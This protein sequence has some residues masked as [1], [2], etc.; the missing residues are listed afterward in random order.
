MRL[1]NIPDQEVIAFIKAE[2]Y[3]ILPALFERNLVNSLNISDKFD[4]AHKKVYRYL[5]N[6]VVIVWQYFSPKPWL[7][8]KHKIDFVIDFIYRYQLQKDFPEQKIKLK[9]S[10]DEFIP[11]I[12]TL[13]EEGQE[14]NGPVIN[15][16]K[17]LKERTKTILWFSFFERIEDDLIAN[18]LGID[19]EKVAKLRAKGIV[20]WCDFVNQNLK[21]KLEAKCIEVNEQAFFK[22][23][24]GLLNQN[25][26]LQ[27]ELL[28]SSD[29]IIT[30]AFEQYKELANT[31][32]LIRRL[33]LREYVLKNASTKLTGN[34][35]GNKISI[36]SAIFI[37]LV[38]I[39]VWWADQ[40]PDSDKNLFKDDVNINDTLI[41]SNESDTIR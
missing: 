36:A 24:K 11:F 16:F 17:V 41:N 21:L 34:I 30:K 31:I 28:L 38:G 1:K 20:K 23:Q 6:A 29:K 2:K 25:E 27:F 15:N 22:Y 39:L 12:H 32:S 9:Y 19:E 5:A 33:T 8:S 4:L 14:E 35:W 3:E 7:V 40:V 13:Y 26:S 18:R 10:F 37:A